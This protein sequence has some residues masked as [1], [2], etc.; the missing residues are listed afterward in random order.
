MMGTLSAVAL[1][2]IGFMAVSFVVLG[3]LQATQGREPEKS[4][5]VGS[6]RERESDGAGN[7]ATERSTRPRKEAAQKM[8]D[9]AAT[10]HMLRT[11][12][13]RKLALRVV[14]LGLIVTSALMIWKTLMVVSGSE[15]PVVVVLS[16]SMEPGFWRGD[17]LFLWLGSAPFRVGEV[18]VF[19]LP[20]RDVPIVHR[21][22]KVHQKHDGRTDILTKG[23]NNEDDDRGL[24]PPGERF[25][26]EKYV[27]GRAVGYLPGVGYVTLVMN[28]YPSF[29]FALLGLLAVFAVTR[30]QQ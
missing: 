16:G 28:D 22:I 5:E 2:G 1:E 3:A 12:R 11:M 13:K 29:K 23:D 8:G 10:I 15:T 14:N 19:K 6:G 4:S 17:I 9:F 24:Y 21:I 27:I 26:N 25:L 7:Q 20:D 30:E 18:V